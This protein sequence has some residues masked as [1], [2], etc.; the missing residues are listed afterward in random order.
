MSVSANDLY[1]KRMF[2]SFIQHVDGCT[3]GCKAAAPEYATAKLCNIG[4]ARAISWEQAQSLVARDAR[5]GVVADDATAAATSPK[6]TTPPTSPT[7]AR[8]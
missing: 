8:G 3:K 7:S 4:K 5:K 1:A 6:P 2:D